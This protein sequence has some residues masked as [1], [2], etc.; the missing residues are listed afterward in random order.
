MKNK[1]ARRTLDM[2]ERHENK[3][4]CS[5]IHAL[6]NA[7]SIKCTTAYTPG[8]CTGDGPGAV[9]TQEQIRQIT[10]THFVAGRDF[11]AQVGRNA[12]SSNDDARHRTP[13]EDSG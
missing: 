10:R 13:A 7:D 12:G 11:N 9:S 8:S 6:G 4:H 2:K 5:V 1:V 3:E